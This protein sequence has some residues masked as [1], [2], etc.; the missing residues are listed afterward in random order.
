[1]FPRAS[2][3]RADDFSALYG[4]ADDLIARGQAEQ[5]ALL[6]EEGGQA[7]AFQSLFGNAGVSATALSQDPVWSQTD[8]VID[9]MADLA[10]GFGDC[11]IESRFQT[12]TR[13]VHLP[14]IE[15]CQQVQQGGLCT[16]THA[17]E[18]PP[19]DRSVSVS[20][21]AV[22]RSCGHGCIEVDYDFT[23]A[24]PV[25]SCPTCDYLPAQTFG[26]IVH[27][28]ER[29]ERITVSVQPEATEFE[30]GCDGDC[31]IAA[32]DQA[33]SIAFPGYAQADASQ[34]SFEPIRRTAVSDHDATALLGNGGSFTVRNDYRYR[35]NVGD[36][37][38][39]QAPYRVS[40]RIA[41]TPVPLMDHGW[42]AP[43]AC[44]HLAQT[45][46]DGALCDGKALCGGAPP[47]A[48]DGCYEDLG[49]RVCPQDFGPSPVPWL[50]P[51]CREL[52]IV[53]D[54]AGFNS[55]PMQC[56][57]DPQGQ[58][59]CPYN[60]GDIGD[61]CERLA[62]DP[63]CGYL[64]ATCIDGA[65]DPR[66]Y[67]YAAEAR[68]DCGTTTE[69]PDVTRETAMDCAGPVRCLGNDCLDLT[70]EQS[71]DFAEAAAALQTAQFVLSDSDC[72]G[73]DRCRVFRGK[74]AEC[75]R[76]VGGVVDCCKRPQGV[77]LV[78]YLQLIFAVTKIDAAIMASESGTT[79]RG[80]WELLRDPLVDTWDAVTET[81]TSAANNLV[82]NT[83]AASSEAGA[84]LSLQAAKQALLRQTAEW[85]A[86]VFGDA[87]VNTLFAVEGGGPAVV[88]GTVQ[89]G[90]LQLGGLIGTTLAWAMSAYM[91]Y[92]VVMILIRIIWTCEKDEF[93]LGVK[94][95]LRSCHYVGSYCDSKILGVCIEKQKAF[96]CFNTPLARIINEQA[97]PQLGRS[98]GD[99]EH[100]DCSGLSLHELQR[101]DWSRIDLS[102]WLAILSQAG[103]FP[104]PGDL[105]I[106][107]LT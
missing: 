64:G 106:E 11:A 14:E 17:Y 32:L 28:P 97:Y 105:D 60:A 48:P 47:L 21:G 98:W 66:G 75:K 10:G 29:I 103:Q 107:A 70:F 65:R 46:R 71:D 41:F 55:G 1:M 38:V 31:G 3:G 104:S 72:T 92:S 30:T 59:H 86:Q 34:A 78:D 99:P 25:P 19:A 51:F 96:C 4:Q 73:A 2:A 91:I 53:S 100:P 39:A 40:V 9:Q 61:D 15:T 42:D 13:S 68:Y 24:A 5:S 84:R 18:L 101:L 52:T 50:S 76:A 67:C 27:A 20:G 82:G 43:E 36:W 23:G 45:I 102:E 22:Q 37:H 80:G 57:T 44:V 83:A 16:L 94:R 33:W 95:E 90:N 49:V 62:S 8:S 89:A 56:W 93:E 54:C 81:V 7:D 77:S 69:I 12:E 79:L 87:A 26:F 63:N 85:T 74:A 6:G 35:T 88:N 58:E